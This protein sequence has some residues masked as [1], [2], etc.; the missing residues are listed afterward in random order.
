MNGPIIM[1][2][3]L[4]VAAMIAG[5]AFFVARKL[6]PQSALRV[7]VDKLVLWIQKNP[8]LFEKRLQHVAFGLLCTVFL[9]LTLVY[10]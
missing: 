7:G 9:V 3:F 4:V 6:P 2:A 8:R 1:A 5:I 10:S